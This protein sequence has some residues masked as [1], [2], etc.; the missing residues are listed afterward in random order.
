M[1]ID[2]MGHPVSADPFHQ[3]RWQLEEDGMEPG[4]RML[5]QVFQRFFLILAL[6]DNRPD[7]VPLGQGIVDHAPRIARFRRLARAARVGGKKDSHSELVN[8]RM[9]GGGTVRSPRE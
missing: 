7:L 1:I 4:H 6:L 2:R 9:E 5:G 3:Q 8:Y